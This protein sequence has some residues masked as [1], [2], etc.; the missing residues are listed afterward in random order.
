[1]K[2][3]FSIAARHDLRAIYLQ[4]YELFGRKQADVYAAGL[5]AALGMIA[6]YPL[7]FRLR[8]ETDL[9]VYVRSFRLH[10][11]IY[12]VDEAGVLILRVR[13]GHEDWQD[14]LLDGFPSG[15]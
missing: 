7:S 15:E 5:G 8:G 2:V 12:S 6:D 9:P 4:G 10:V 3:R 13:H 14:D 11:I 1:M